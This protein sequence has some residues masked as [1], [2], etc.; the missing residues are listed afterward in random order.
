MDNVSLPLASEL[1]ESKQ[2]KSKDALGIYGEELAAGYL[3]K[4]GLVILGRNWRCDLGE[5]DVIAREKKRPSNLRSQNS[6]HGGLR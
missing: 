4:N 1:S 5:I 2:M 6:T 3:S